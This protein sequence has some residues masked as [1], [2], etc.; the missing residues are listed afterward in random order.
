M[1]ACRHSCHVMA[2]LVGVV[3]LAGGCATFAPP[4]HAEAELA[5]WRQAR[6]A[7]YR[8]ER[9]VYVGVNVSDFRWHAKLPSW[10]NSAELI[11]RS[12]QQWLGV[13]PDDCMLLSDPSRARLATLFT[14]ELPGRLGPNDTLVVY[15]GTH[16]LKNGRILLGG[17]TETNSPELAR[18]LDLLPQRK[19]VLADVCYAGK[20][21][22]NGRFASNVVRFH[23]SGAKELTPEI[24]L[25]PSY[26]DV[27]RH[28]YVTDNIVR[29]ELGLSYY[30]YSMMGYAFIHALRLEVQTERNELTADALFERMRTQQ[31]RLADSITRRW[32]PVPRAVNL[33]PWVLAK[34]EPRLVQLRS[35]INGSEAPTDDQI[36]ANTDARLKA[37]MDA[38]DEEIDIG[39]G[40]L[41]IGKLYEPELDV[42][43]YSEQLDRIAAE[44]KVRIAAEKEPAAVIKIINDYL[45]KKV[46]LEAI[47]DPYPTDFLLHVLLR[48]KRGRCSALVALYMAL[49][50]RLDLPLQSVCVPAH[51]FVRW[52]LEPGPAGADTPRYL[53]I[54]TTMQGVLMTDKQYQESR[55]WVETERAGKF[56]LQSLTKRQT[57]AA[58]LSPL[59]SALR[60]QGR[61]AEAVTYCRKA[62]AALPNDAEGWNNL[63][64]AYRRLG[65]NGLA[66]AS[67]RQALL[68]NPGYAEFWN[69]QGSAMEDVRARVEHF[70]R[71]V[72]IKP[73]LAEAW[74]NLSYAYFEMRQIELAWQSAQKCKELGLKLPPEF[75]KALQLRLEQRQK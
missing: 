58:F 40:N 9:L 42:A 22:E 24:Y 17:D 49:G 35:Q 55:G 69:N 53:N 73:D 39:L 70:R 71:A 47:E 72:Q 65:R 68:I 54:E 27:M 36:A 3:L 56:Y 21:E 67:F 4:P 19:M 38:P 48:T 31:I 16:H 46:G 33:Q 5:A 52:V 26:A 12:L 6:Q 75:I 7:V 8:P 30:S 15:L 44:L 43:K 10:E 61:L 23:A 1:T 41:L 66:I 28:Y 25:H 11:S 32:K 51:T 74:K 2:F 13:S 14:S 20:L 64:M 34:K 59:G 63:G 60:H 50:R 29:Q 37:V 62:I 45:F 18:W 57:L